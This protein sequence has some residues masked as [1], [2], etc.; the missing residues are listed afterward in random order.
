MKKIL[1]CVLC[2]A[3]LPVLASD[4]K[5]TDTGLDYQLLKYDKTKAGKARCD[6]EDEDCRTAC[7]RQT[8]SVLFDE[9]F[10]YC[11]DEWRFCWWINE[12]P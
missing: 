10:N 12:W 11:Y 8:Q 2:L 7:R 3:A 4:S 9:C 5:I 1:I 6:A